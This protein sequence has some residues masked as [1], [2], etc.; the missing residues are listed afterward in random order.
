M[1]KKKSKSIFGDIAF[2]SV[3]SLV[4]LLSEWGKGK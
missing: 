3:A 4:Y 1:K 2:C